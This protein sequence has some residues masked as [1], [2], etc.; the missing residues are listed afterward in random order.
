MR[1]SKIKRNLLR[2]QQIIQGPNSGCLSSIIACDTTNPRLVL[3]ETV[4]SANEQFNEAAV[5]DRVTS[6]KLEDATLELDELIQ[7]ARAKQENAEVSIRS[8]AHGFYSPSNAS[9]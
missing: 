3:L 1:A 9:S 7:H 6:K 2:M 5:N 8:M 4:E